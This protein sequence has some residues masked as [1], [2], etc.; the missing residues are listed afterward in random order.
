MRIGGKEAKERW[1]PVFFRR[2][3]WPSFIHAPT[4]TMM[5]ART[6]QDRLLFFGPALLQARLL[7]GR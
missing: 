5:R 6:F 3:S 4:S 1:C 2:Q 7:R